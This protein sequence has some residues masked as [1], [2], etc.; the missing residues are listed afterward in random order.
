MQK[1]RLERKMMEGLLREVAQGDFFEKRRYTQGVRLL[2]AI[3]ASQCQ[4]CGHRR[5]PGRQRE[6]GVELEE[7]IPAQHRRRAA[8]I[9]SP[10]HTE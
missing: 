1:V 6:L 5:C 2:N 10:Q 3:E 9:R 8:E 4:A 7:A